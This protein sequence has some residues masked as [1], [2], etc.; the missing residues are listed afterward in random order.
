[1]DTISSYLANDHSRCDALYLQAF[2][3]V[4]ERQWPQAER[5][6]RDFERALVRHLAVEEDIVFHAFEQAIGSTSGPTSA[7]RGEH[8]QLRGIM[9]RLADAVLQRHSLDFF[10]HADTFGIVLH[11]HGMKE[12]GIFYP[13]LDRVLQRRQDELVAAMSARA[14]IGR[15]AVLS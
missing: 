1:M 2:T 5:A 10:D 14:G 9:Y 6:F 8:L 4:L 12:E 11:Q 3:R 7:L 13:M 15:I